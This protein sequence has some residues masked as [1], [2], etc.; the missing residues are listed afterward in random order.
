MW[1]RSGFLEVQSPVRCNGDCTALVDE[2]VR[3]RQLPDMA[4]HGPRFGHEAILEVRSERF[5]VLLG[6]RWIRGED[7][8]Y[9]RPEQQRVPSS[10]IKQ[11]LLAHAVARQQEAA[12]A[13]VP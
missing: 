5:D 1:R 11:R 7:R 13:L 12:C 4:E 2:R 6:E 10:G 3:R 9:F 8:L